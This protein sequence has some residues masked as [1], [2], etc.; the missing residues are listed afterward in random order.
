MDVI[1]PQFAEEC[2]LHEKVIRELSSLA[3]RQSP[4]DQ[5]LNVVGEMVDNTTP[6]SV[7]VIAKVQELVKRRNALKQSLQ[8]NE[9]ALHETKQKLKNQMTT[10]DHKAGKTNQSLVFAKGR[11]STHS[12]VVH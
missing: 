10:N 7:D 4:V 6:E 2:A 5:L 12:F 11:K 8:R 9:R 1:E 3:T